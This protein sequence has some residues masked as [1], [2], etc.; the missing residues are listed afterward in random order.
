[1]AMTII[2]AIHLVL[3]T[4]VALALGESGNLSPQLAAW[5][6]IGFFALLGCWLMQR[7]VAGRALWPLFG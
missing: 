5:L 1:M 4:S 7:R 2:F 3:F 6:P